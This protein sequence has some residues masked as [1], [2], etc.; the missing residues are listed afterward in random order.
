M[1]HD[2]NSPLTTTKHDSGSTFSRRAFVVGVGITGLVAGTGAISSSLAE[3]SAPGPSDFT[4]N[5]WFSMHPDLTT[6]IFIAKAEMGQHVGTALAQALAEE[7]EMPWGRVKILHVDSDPK[8]GF[9]I[10]GG[11]W[12]VNYTFDTMSRAGAAGRLALIGAAAEFLGV[13]AGECSAADAVVRHANSN[14]SIGYG[15]LIS[16]KL[17]SAVIDE[18]EWKSLTLKQ[19]DRYKMVG[20]RV[21]ALDIPAKVNGSGTYGVDVQLP[22]MVYGKPVTPPTRT[23]AKVQEIDD[24]AARKVPGFIKAVVLDDPSGSFE[25]W[26]VAVATSFPAA[27]KAAEALKVSYGRTAHGTIST[28]DIFAAAAKLQKD[29]HSGALW[30]DDGDVSVALARAENVVHAIY[31]TD[32]ALHAQMEPVNA[33]ATQRE[34]VWHFYAGC[35]CQ[36][37]TIPLLCRALAVDPSKIVIHQ[38]F[39]GGGFGRRLYGDY[40][41]PAALTAKALGRAVKILYSRA[42]DMKFDCARSP[43]Y[44]FIEAGL[45][46]NGRIAALRQDVV[47]GWPTVLVMPWL[48]ADS[49]DRKSKVDSFAITGADF[50]YS[51]PNHRVRAIKHELIHQVLPPGYLR[52]VGPGFTQWAAES[53]VDEL[54]VAAKADPLEFRLNHLDGTGKQSGVKPNSAGGAKRLAAVLQEAVRRSG[55]GR[56][57]L[58]PDS[59]F[60][61]AAT[62]GQER[63]MPTFTACVAQVSV[64]R[65]S[66]LVSVRKLTVVSD[67]GRAVNPDGVHSQ[68]QSA[69]LWGLSVALYEQGTFN[70]SAIDHENFD[71]YTPLRMSQV[72]E[73]DVSFMP[74]TEYPVG[75]G[76]PP[77]TAV[78]PA[79]GNAIFRAVGA[80]VRSLPITAEKVKQ[81]IPA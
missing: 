2:L 14:K 19:P 36:G 57:K 22:N 34:G 43:S 11:S 4:P 52:S 35:Q 66:G 50:W 29:P 74:S 44:Q 5:L 33:V 13:P 62:F 77:M 42:D 26:V 63:D 59:A 80:R 37:A 64:E 23:G 81:A 69:T 7:L 70:D 28:E 55:Y 31:T 1:A 65:T 16:R 56:T 45:G 67:V 8:W 71:S 27:M 12:S 68:M 18:D 6:T 75:I 79:I 76:E 73:L 15:E 20:K 49:L 32:L 72:P 78:A 58:A 60:G 41:I 21:A 39:L 53:F 51:V 47:A 38:S 10:T 3:I 9:M 61:I 30:V 25:G 54:A 24:S 46:P 40:L 48:L 17:V